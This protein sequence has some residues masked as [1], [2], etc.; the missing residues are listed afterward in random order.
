MMRQQTDEIN[1]LKKHMK[2]MSSKMEESISKAI[3]KQFI[4]FEN[5]VEKIINYQTSTLET[6]AEKT[7][8]NVVKNKSTVVQT[9]LHT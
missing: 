2:K 3:A 7:F 5:K 1:H 9:C 4:N 8:A 6:N